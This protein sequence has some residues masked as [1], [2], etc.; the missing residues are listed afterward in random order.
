MLKII[1]LLHSIS[2]FCNENYWR[3]R[4]NDDTLVSIKTEKISWKSTYSPHSHVLTVHDK[5]IMLINQL[6]GIYFPKSW[7]NCWANNIISNQWRD[8]C[9]VCVLGIFSQF[10]IWWTVFLV[11]F[12]Y[13]IENCLAQFI[14]RVRSYFFKWVTDNRLLYWLPVTFC[15]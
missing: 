6:K 7:R 15:K 3:T 12:M 13:M 2:I 14:L 10:V 8:P 11:L 1:C 4:R 5:V 9:N